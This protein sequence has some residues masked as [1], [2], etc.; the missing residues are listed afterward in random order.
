MLEH[1]HSISS[2]TFTLCAAVDTNLFYFVSIGLDCS[3]YITQFLRKTR[4]N[5]ELVASR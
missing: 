2:D 1:V 3:L 4:T 5:D